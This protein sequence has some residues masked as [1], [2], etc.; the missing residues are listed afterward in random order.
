MIIKEKAILLQIDET[1]EG[2]FAIV[3]LIR[4]KGFIRGVVS[5]QLMRFAG[6]L[7]L[8]SFVEVSYRQCDKNLAVIAEIKASNAEHRKHQYLKQ[9]KR[10]NK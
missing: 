4:G 6:D 10:I 5:S 7:R 8:F 2:D 3:F 9:S 1:E